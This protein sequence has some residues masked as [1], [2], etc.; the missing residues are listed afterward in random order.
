MIRSIDM[1]KVVGVDRYVVE[2]GGRFAFQINNAGPAGDQLYI[3]AQVRSEAFLV[4]SKPIGVFFYR[5]KYRAVVCVLLPDLLD[6][7]RDHIGARSRPKF[8]NSLRLALENVP[9]ERNC[10]GQINRR[11]ARRPKLR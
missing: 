7:E 2:D 11:R 4:I 6:S 8:E 9:I 1:N 10:V 3:R 5:D